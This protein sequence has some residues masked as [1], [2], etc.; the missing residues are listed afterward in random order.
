[1]TMYASYEVMM[2]GQRP[3]LTKRK[4]IYIHWYLYADLFS[5][6]MVTSQGIMI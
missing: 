3:F 6:K 4:Y 2:Q 5:K 1:M